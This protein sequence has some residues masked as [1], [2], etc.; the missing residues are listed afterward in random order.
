[1][2]TMAIHRTQPPT[3]NLNDPHHRW[4]NA[5][6]RCS[7]GWSQR[8]ANGRDAAGINHQRHLDEVAR[9]RVALTT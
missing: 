3:W 6:K 9:L 8:R 5:R 4:L 1:M 7:C 2:T